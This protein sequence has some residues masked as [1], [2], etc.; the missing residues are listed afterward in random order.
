MVVSISM[1]TAR[2]FFKKKLRRVSLSITVLRVIIYCMCVMQ[3]SLYQNPATEPDFQ[4][5]LK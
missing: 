3:L 1:Q 5:S 2:V 4:P